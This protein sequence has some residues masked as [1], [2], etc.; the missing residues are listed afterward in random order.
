[1]ILNEKTKDT[2]GS[3]ALGEIWYKFTCKW[4]DAKTCKMP[5]CSNRR[6]KDNNT[7]ILPASQ[8]MFSLNY[9]VLYVGLQ[10]ILIKKIILHVLFQLLIHGTVPEITA[11]MKRLAK[12]SSSIN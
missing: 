12:S 3:N 7:R 10:K 4:C 11:T 6:K 2:M 9:C 5:H 8:Y 1:M